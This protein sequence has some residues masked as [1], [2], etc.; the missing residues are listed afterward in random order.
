MRKKILIVDDSQAILD[1]VAESL[2]SEGYEVTSS[3]NGQ[4]AFNLLQN[5]SFDLIITDV[6]MPV[7]DGIELIAKLRELDSCKYTPI[8]ILTTEDDYDMKMKGKHA[9][10][11]GWLVKP[12]VSEQ[13]LNTVARV[14]S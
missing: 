7:M 2:Q 12:I 9:G 13:L 14:F 8:L 3:L 1:L 11:T 4:L 10:A 6:Y 5:E